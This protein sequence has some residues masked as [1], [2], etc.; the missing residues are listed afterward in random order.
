MCFSIIV[1]MTLRAMVE[2]IVNNPTLFS[3][4]NPEFDMANVGMGC[5]CLLL[6]GALI[7]G[8]VSVAEGITG[9]LIGAEVDKKFQ[10]NLVKILDKVKGWT[11]K[12]LS[13][14][15]SAGTALLPA[16]IQEYIK[17]AQEAK[18]RVDRFAGRSK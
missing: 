15:V 9:S 13:G 3:P 6:I 4:E 14:F 17:K 18:A 1:A 11:L 7:Y 5:L 12:G 2:L 8:S 16:G 10:E